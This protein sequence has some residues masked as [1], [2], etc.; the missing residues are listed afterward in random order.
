MHNFFL[1]GDVPV[2]PKATA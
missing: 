2:D 1:N